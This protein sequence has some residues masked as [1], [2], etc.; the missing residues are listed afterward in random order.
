MAEPRLIA[1]GGIPAKNMDGMGQAFWGRRLV[2]G[3]V[4][5]VPRELWVVCHNSETCLS[6]FIIGG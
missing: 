5:G 2:P 6:L 4:G 3:V 1:K